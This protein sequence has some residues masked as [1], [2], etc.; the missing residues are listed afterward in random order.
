MSIITPHWFDDSVRLGRCLPETPYL[1]PDPVVLRSG[2]L[3]VLEDNMINN[4]D[5][6]RRNPAR[7]DTAKDD[8][9]VESHAE[10]A[11]VWEGRRILLSLSLELSQGQRDAVEAGIK[12]AGGTTVDIEHCGDFDDAEEKAVNK[13]D[14][15]V[16]RWRSGKAYFKVS[17]I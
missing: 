4:S 16:T 17:T 13:C 1:W 14:V 5:G 9:A 12:R 3:P 8:L 11:E 6:K 7:S 2:A 15:F 10:N